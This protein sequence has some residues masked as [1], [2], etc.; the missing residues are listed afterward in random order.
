MILPSVINISKKPHF[1]LIEKVM[2]LVNNVDQLDYFFNESKKWFFVYN[3][4]LSS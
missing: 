1:R 4:D 2:Y 3:S